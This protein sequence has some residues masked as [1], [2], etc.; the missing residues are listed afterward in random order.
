MD[1]SIGLHRP[2][3][4]VQAG[5]NSPTTQQVSALF[6]EVDSFLRAMNI[7]P[8]V[9]DAMMNAEPEEM[10][11]LDGDEIDNWFPMT[12]P[13]YDEVSTSDNARRYGIGTLEYRQID[14]MDVDWNCEAFALYSDERS[15]CR[16]RTSGNPP[17]FNG[18][19]S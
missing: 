13:V 9:H 12:D 15:I 4:A 11:V 14:A 7:T 10:T 17:I 3:F 2:Y 6:A 16:L 1:S 5:G 8:R 19:Q 18:V